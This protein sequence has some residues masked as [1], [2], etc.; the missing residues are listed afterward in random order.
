MTA[1]LPAAIRATAIGASLQKSNLI[2]AIVAARF[3]SADAATAL[4]R[5]W[6]I[7]FNV[8]ITP[9]RIGITRTIVGSAQFSIAAHLAS[10]IFCADSR[11]FTNFPISRTE[12]EFFSSM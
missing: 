3:I 2:P 7:V 8:A 12:C 6:I 1:Y 10:K 11:A 5:K 4:M 9:F